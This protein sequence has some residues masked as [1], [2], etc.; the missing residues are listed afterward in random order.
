MRTPGS[1]I[2][3]MRRLLTSATIV[4]AAGLTLTACGGPPE[5]A[6]K[7]DFCKAIDFSKVSD[8]PDQD[9]VDEFIEKLE[10][11]GTP[12]GIPDDAREGFEKFVDVISDIDVDDDEDDIT[13]QIED[14]VDGDD[15]DNINAL[16]AY[17]A[18]TCA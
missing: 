5:D 3:T 7:D 10:D 11:T 13:K 4:L 12:K 18:K 6:S 1:E 14:D 8:D 16:F 17:V 15:E 9:E 2:H